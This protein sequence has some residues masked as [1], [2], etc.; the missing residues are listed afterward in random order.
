MSEEK[1]LNKEQEVQMNEEIQDLNE[2]SN[3]ETIA[4]EK[5]ELT[6]EDKYNEMNDKFMRLYAE[7]DNYR[8]RTNKEK[9]RERKNKEEHGKLCV[10]F[11]DLKL[12]ATT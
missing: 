8:R 1:E 9:G 2:D 6:W 10:S 4:E 11:F 7:F 3:S 5:V 12:S